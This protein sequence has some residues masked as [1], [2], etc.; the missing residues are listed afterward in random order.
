MRTTQDLKNLKDVRKLLM[1][2]NIRICSSTT[3]NKKNGSEQ[4]KPRLAAD[5]RKLLQKVSQISQMPNEK[6]FK[7]TK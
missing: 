3:W 7:K 5:Q 4:E 6:L 2:V 1:E